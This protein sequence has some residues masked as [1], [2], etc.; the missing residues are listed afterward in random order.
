M[1]FPTLFTIRNRFLIFLCS[2]AFLN[3][4]KGGG[5]ISIS[6]NLAAAS[7]VSANIQSFIFV[8]SGSS[9]QGNPSTQL[10]SKE[11]IG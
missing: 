9:L 4:T 5:E 11:C 8:V 10:F 3:C 1:R 6:L 7:G 2:L